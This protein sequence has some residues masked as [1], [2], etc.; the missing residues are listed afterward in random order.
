[1]VKGISTKMSTTPIPPELIN[2]L[3]PF[4]FISVHSWLNKITRGSGVRREWV[5]LAGTVKDS[6]EGKPAHFL[7]NEIQTLAFA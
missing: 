4:V 3:L 7:C 2:G 5:R 6:G 1:L